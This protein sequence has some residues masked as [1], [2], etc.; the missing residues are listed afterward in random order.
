MEN[1]MNY[2]I[3]KL[4]KNQKIECHEVRATIIDNKHV[5][6]HFFI[7]QY[8]EID[9][10][11]QF[12][13]GFERYHATV[14]EISKEDKPNKE[15]LEHYAMI[16]VSEHDTVLFNDP[17]QHE[18]QVAQRNEWT[19][20]QPSIAANGIDESSL[21]PNSPENISVNKN[22]RYVSEMADNSIYAT[23]DVI[24]TSTYLAK[25]DS[26]VE[27]PNALDTLD[28]VDSTKSHSIWTSEI[29][30]DKYHKCSNEELLSLFKKYKHYIGTSIPKNLDT[31]T[32]LN[33]DMEHLFGASFDVLRIKNN[34]FSD[35][36]SNDDNLVGGTVLTS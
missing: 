7:T 33:I 35:N 15:K 10:L 31:E 36:D 3:E 21:S 1:I 34:L 32:N 28:D 20:E 14:Q 23:D 9:S 8:K 11:P 6:L 22:L 18:E 27:D 24:T 13:M 19:G 5:L 26:A 29:H 16:N 17:E 4:L 12:K 30:W 2:A 25:K